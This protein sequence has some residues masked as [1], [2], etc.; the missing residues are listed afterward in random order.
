MAKGKKTG[1]RV[2]GVPNKVNRPIVEK[3]NKLWEGYSEE[4]MMADILELP[5]NERLKIMIG[6]AAEFVA[7]KLARQEVDLTTEGEKIQV[8]IVP[9]GKSDKD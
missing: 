7:P 9:V 6:M 3:L 8:N 5:A 1:G 2:K 4:Q